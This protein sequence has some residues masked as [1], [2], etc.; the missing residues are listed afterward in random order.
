MKKLFFILCMILIASDVWAT[1]DG[2]DSSSAYPAALDTTSDVC[3]A[4]QNVM[5]DEASATCWDVYDASSGGDVIYA[6]HWDAHSDAIIELETKVGTGDDEATEGEFLIGTGSQASEWDML[7]EVSAK[8]ASH[9]VTAAE[10]KRGVIFTNDGESDDADVTFTLPS[11]AA[12]YKFTLLV[13]D[14]MSSYDII[15]DVDASDKMIA[16]VSGLDNGDQIEL[17]TPEVGEYIQCIGISIS[18]W[19]CISNTTW[20]DGG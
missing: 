11:V 10:C 20:T 18:E 15:I 13:S 12:G 14:A 5:G 6:D 16:V 1:A 8:T 4:D 9:S 2:L 3:S 17:D 7:H 19:W